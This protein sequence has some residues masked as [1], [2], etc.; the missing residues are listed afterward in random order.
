LAD[1]EALTVGG[2]FD[3]IGI[4]G[5]SDTGGVSLGVGNSGAA[6]IVCHLQAF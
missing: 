2:V 5:V 6:T 3:N 1:F 4:F